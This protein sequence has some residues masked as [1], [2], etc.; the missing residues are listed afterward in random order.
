MKEKYYLLSVFIFITF[1]SCK[2][3]KIK[4][5]EQRIDIGI[6]LGAPKFYTAHYPIVSFF[7]NDER[8]GG[9]SDSN[10]GDNLGWSSSDS[11]QSIHGKGDYPDSIFVE[12]TDKLTCNRYE[13]GLKLPSTFINNYVNKKLKQKEKYNSF[14]FTVNFAPGGNFCVFLNDIEIK[15]GVANFTKIDS[16]C[17]AQNGIS[18]ISN[19]YYKKVG[20]DYSNWQK[21][22]PRYALGLGYYTVDTTT[23]F[24]WAN[25]VSKEGIFT[26]NDHLYKSKEN[27]IYGGKIVTFGN[28]YMT[29]NDMDLKTNKFQLPVLIQTFWYREKPKDSIYLYTNI[30]LPKNFVKIYTTPYIN[31]KN[32]KLTN[33]NH[34]I[35]GVEKDGRYCTIWLD[36]PG[37]REKLMRFEA[38]DAIRTENDLV[39]PG[40]YAKNIIYYK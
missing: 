21:S 31:P 24:G 8:V 1:L 39:Y 10:V 25:L 40:G 5:E 11:N 23:V 12:W 33:Y 20:L 4:D 36:G 9:I 29:I 22:D 17:I 16:N 3:K 19:E 32:N 6:S 7:K 30:P 2:D 15:R 38:L 28:S 26:S 18:K 37:K 35:F 27:E 13:G 14:D 34:L